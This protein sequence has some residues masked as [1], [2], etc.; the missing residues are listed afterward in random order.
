MAENRTSALRKPKELITQAVNAMKGPSVEAL[1]EDFTSEMTLVAEGLCE[2]QQRLRKE[3][4]Q[5][6]AA[7]QEGQAQAL[8]R[9]ERLENR[10]DQWERETDARLRELQARQAEAERKLAKTKPKSSLLSQATL[11]AAILAGAWV[12][13]TLLNLLKG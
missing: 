1:I 12:L 5:L 7:L 11:L 10:L 6:K 4:E 13:V 9:V 2:D 8:A 3:L